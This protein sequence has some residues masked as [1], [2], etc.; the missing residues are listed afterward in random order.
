M[1]WIVGTTSLFGHSILAADVCVTFTMPNGQRTYLDCLQK[2][3]P[4]GRFLVGGFAGSVRIGFAVI[5]A[6]CKIFNEIPQTNAIDLESMAPV[7]LPQI[8]REIFEASLPSE[9]VLG[10]QIII[11]WVHPIRNLDKGLP[12]PC[13][14]SYVY[15]L[16][17]PDFQ[18]IQNRPL[19]IMAIGSGAAMEQHMRNARNL[20]SAGPVMSWHGGGKKVATILA[21]ML[22]NELEKRPM[23]GV[24][25]FFQI[26]VAAR[27]HGVNI[28]HH[29][30]GDIHF[31][32]VARTYSEFALMCRRVGMVA[33][34]S[35]ATS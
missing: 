1:T 33:E 3:H 26:G 7:A 18:V 4:L 10:C 35:V 16:G 29:N 6:L 34:G 31:P 22:G 23:P 32:V 17:S 12:Q 9:Q 5:D 28:I 27:G 13:P 25:A 20:F 2:I 14:V 30:Q 24:S 11:G 21:A 15:T 19:D 8:V